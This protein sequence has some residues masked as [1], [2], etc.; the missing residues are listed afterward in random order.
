MHEVDGLTCEQPVH[1]VAAGGVTAQQPVATQQPEV[2]RLGARFVGRLGHV[3]RVPLAILHLADR[4]LRVVQHPLDR[5]IVEARQRAQVLGQRGEQLSQLGYVPR[6]ADLVERDVQCPGL[7]VGDVELDH[8]HALEADLLGGFKPLVPADDLAALPSHEDRVNEAERADAG[9]QRRHLL[10]RHRARVVRRRHEVRDGNLPDRDLRARGVH[11][12][13]VARV[14]GRHHSPRVST[15]RTAENTRNSQ[16][17]RQRVSLGGTM[18]SGTASAGRQRRAIGP[19]VAARE[20]HLVAN[21]KH[22]VGDTPR[23]NPVEDCL[24]PLHDEY[25]RFH[26]AHER[27]SI[28]VSVALDRAWRRYNVDALEPYF[29]INMGSEYA[30]RFMRRAREPLLRL[31]RWESQVRKFYRLKWEEAKSGPDGGTRIQ[32]L[33][34]LEWWDCLQDLGDDSPQFEEIKDEYEETMDAFYKVIEYLRNQ[35]ATLRGIQTD[36]DAR[37]PRRGAPL[38]PSKPTGKVRSI[39]DDATGP[40]TMPEIQR[41][42]RRRGVELEGRG[43]NRILSKLVSNHRWKR[44]YERV[45]SPDGQEER[46]VRRRF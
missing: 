42:L 41:E 17:E 24:V 2:A 26:S 28:N 21:G 11:R 40:L 13:V 37:Q 27:P 25:V 6:S 19:V 3:V 32:N 15:R 22:D 44:I 18:M 46:Y 9:D 29:E 12:S 34:K 30:E 45:E 39:L 23:G 4:L 7:L 10:R 38:N 31:R 8:G 5:R 14:L 1:V 16:G 35:L 20:S 36:R 33:L 43:L